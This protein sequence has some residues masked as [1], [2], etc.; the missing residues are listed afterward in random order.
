MKDNFHPKVGDEVWTTNE[1]HLT[2]C[3]KKI[4]S[5]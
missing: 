2:P 1:C 3:V 5:I 4:K